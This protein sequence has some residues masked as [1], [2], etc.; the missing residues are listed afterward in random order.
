MRASNKQANLEESRSGMKRLYE[1]AKVLGEGQ[2]FP[3][4]RS[5]AILW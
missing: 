3:W 4:K 2:Y 5:R 1:R